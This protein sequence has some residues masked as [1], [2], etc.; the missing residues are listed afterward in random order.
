MRGKPSSGDATEQGQWVLVD[1]S[2]W[3]EALRSHGQA[4]CREA[5]AQL[6]ATGQGATCDVVL[7]EVLRGA[8]NES[9]AEAWADSLLSLR[10]LR[11]DG[12]G[13][14]AAHIG[15]AMRDA[16]TSPPLGDLLV[17]AVAL[18]HGAVVLHRDRHLHQIAATIGIEDVIPADT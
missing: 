14:I 13:L 10:V 7:T 16:G 5:I 1:T 9:Q 2:I 12:V 6:V 4:G 3:V 18:K 8:R 17:A 11:S 15:R